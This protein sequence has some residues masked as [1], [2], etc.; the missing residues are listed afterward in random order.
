MYIFTN[1][2]SAV[3][4]RRDL[5]VCSQ[6]RYPLDLSIIL[7]YHPQGEGASLLV[8]VRPSGDTESFIGRMTDDGHMIDVADFLDCRRTHLPHIQLARQMVALAVDLPTDG[9][10]R[11]SV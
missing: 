2:P 11:P 6:N 5:P 3:P 4:F 7:T 9:A 8:A 1:V 10:F